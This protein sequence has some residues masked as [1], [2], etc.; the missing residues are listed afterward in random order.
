MLKTKWKWLMLFAFLVT[1]SLCLAV[2]ASAQKLVDQD[3]LLMKAADM[4]MVRVIVTIDVDNYDRLLSA[5]QAF[6]VG[7][8]NL[9][10]IQETK[11]AD[12]ALA[13]AI[14]SA[15][16][17]VVDK[18]GNGS[19]VYHHAFK[20]VPG[21]V[22]S[23]SA[24]ALVEL[25]AMPEVLGVVEDRLIPLPPI[26]E[27]ETKGVPR[28]DDSTVQVGADDA[29]DAGYTGSGWYVAILDT[30]VR[31]SHEFFSGKT[32]MEACYNTNDTGYSSSTTCPNG[33][34]S[35]TGSGAAWPPSIDG[36]YHG[37]HVAGIATGYNSNPGSGEPSAGVAKGADVIAVNVFSR[38]DNADACGGSTPC[39]LSWNSDQVRG[40]EY[41]YSLRSQVNIA[42]A[43]M[44]LGGGS[45][46]S[47]CD[48]E[49]QKTAI[50]NLKAVNVATAIS[51][52]NSYLCGSIGSP[53]CISSAVAVGSVN[54]SDVKSSF[55]NWH[56]SLQ[57]LFAPGENINS[58]LSTSDTSYGLLDGTSMAAP[59]VAGAWAIMR[60]A[61]PTS[62]VDTILSKLQNNGQTINVTNCSPNGSSTRIDIGQ[63][64]GSGGTSST[65]DLCW[66]NDSYGYFGVETY[67]GTTRLAWNYMNKYATDWKIKAVADF[68]GDGNLDVL[69]RNDT[70][71]YFGWETYNGTTRIAW[72]YINRYSLSWDIRGVGDYNGDGQLDLLWRNSSTGAFG[73]ETYSGTTRLG[74]SYINTYATNWDLRGAGDFNGDGN[75]DLLWRN[76]SYGY[77]GWETY[78]GTTR[79]AWNY[80]NKY[81][82]NWD[83]RGA[84]DFNG[85][86]QLDLLWRNST[87]GYFGW[88]TYSGTT[89]LAWNYINKYA[90]D[91]DL[92]GVGAY[93]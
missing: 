71:G 59:H 30:G 29:W 38:F 14:D 75:I 79:L 4:G 92:R 65:P 5:S 34:E 3:G 73:W 13:E 24:E 10:L 56:P 1:L 11:T 31:T 17:G 25:E 85:D 35:Q 18:L 26:E 16:G 2:S 68:N 83:L 69:W 64:I 84:D 39:V 61:F 87:Y 21:L 66:Q 37:T 57:D 19:F 42:S 22:L 48:T 50:D 27:K 6:K 46:S 91:W 58:S 76:D 53:G 54:K 74:W 62:S 82:L 15:A 88:E 41:V 78:N 20:T 23:V 43:N 36:A 7:E 49:I 89:R 93:D 63:A 8:K 67:N 33:S 28:L 72:N 80:I 60:Q 51:T 55:S 47:H 32:F 90:L 81:A 45:Y 70:Y 12:A 52:G 40:L 86:G 77:F 9:N 44:S